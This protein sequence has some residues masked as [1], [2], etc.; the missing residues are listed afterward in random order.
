MGSR[1]QEFPHQF[2]GHNNSYYRWNYTLLRDDEAELDPGYFVSFMPYDQP[3]DKIGKLVIKT[4]N[5]DEYKP[6]TDSHGNMKYEN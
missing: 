3:T 5:Y 4:G 6:G 2:P 1:Y